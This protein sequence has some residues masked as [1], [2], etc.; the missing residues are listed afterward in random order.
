MENASTELHQTKPFLSQEE[1]PTAPSSLDA[2][3]AA[4]AGLLKGVVDET[5]PA[6]IIAAYESEDTSAIAKLATSAGGLLTDSLR[7]K[8][9]TYHERR[10]RHVDHTNQ[11]WLP[12]LSLA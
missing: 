1:V 5:K 9:C 12:N 2:I 4:Q 7:Q 10:Q 8:A 11:T 6:K 3:N